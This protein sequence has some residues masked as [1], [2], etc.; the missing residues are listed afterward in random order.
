MNAERYIAN[1]II[2]PD[3]YKGTISKPI[4]KIGIIGIALGISVMI[5]TISV[6]FGFKK[7]IISKI[8]GITSHVSITNI[9]INS[10]NE[11]DPVLISDD[12]LKQIQS[13]PFIK[14]IQR[15][16]VKN[17]II[18]TKSENEG[19]FF[20]GVTPDYDFTFIKKYLIEGELPSYSDSLSG[21]QILISKKL[22]DRMDIKLGQKLLAYF[23]TKKNVIDSSFS[24]STYV[25]YEQRSRDFKVCG[26]FNTGFSDFDNNLAF[27]DLKQIQKLNYWNGGEVGSYE[28]IL[29]NFSELS[30]SV[31]KIEDTLGYNYRIASVKDTY[32]NI[33][34]WLDMIDVNGI[35][36]LVLMLLVAG[37]NMITALLILILERTNMVGLLKSVGMSNAGVRKIFFYVSIKLLTRGLIIGNI[38]GVLI[39]LLQYYFQIIK[40]DSETYYI[41]HVPVIFDA[42]YIVSLNLG[43]IICCIL[44]LF[45]PTLILTRLTPIKTLRFD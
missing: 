30:E 2:H 45:F 17:G 25:K 31:E 3:N 1:R 32:N 36:I 10:S 20:K 5:L 14:K 28:I 43:T 39:V 26:V 21:K 34:S 8:T 40:L 16:A 44:M 33:F 6:V 38:S 15:I 19:V 11:P 37:V 23:I 18:K 22:A 7:E 29:N 13:L 4:V 12:T 27:V 42:V 24:G 35:I 9:N 41:E